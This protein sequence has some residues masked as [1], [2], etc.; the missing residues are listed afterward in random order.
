MDNWVVLLIIAGFGIIVFLSVYFSDSAKGKRKLKKASFKKI[1]DF[2]MGEIGKVVGHVEFIDPPLSAPLTGRICAHYHILVEQETNSG[3][4]SQWKTLVKEEVSSRYL[5]RGES[6]CAFVQDYNIKRYIVQDRSFSS[7][8]MDDPHVRLK[9]YLKSKGQDS[10]N[11]LGFNKTLRYKEGILEENEVIAVFGV[12]N[13]KEAAELN[14]PA[15]LGKVLEI[16]AP[17][18][19]AVYLSDDPSTTLKTVK[20]ESVK[21]WRE[22][23]N[24]YAREDGEKR[25]KR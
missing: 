1:S 2:K 24:P 20:E 4:N 14:L 8:F 3:K 13:W 15:E 9:A 6:G 12:G 22:P 7:G 11:S 21:E 23:K 16:T 10:E 18:E 5:I 25:Y 19:D 17:A